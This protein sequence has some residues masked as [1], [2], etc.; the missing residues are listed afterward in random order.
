[1]QEVGNK[2]VAFCGNEGVFFFYGDNFA[3]FGP[4]LECIVLIGLYD[5]S[6]TV[7]IMV[8]AVTRDGATSNRVD[9]GIDFKG[10]QGEVSYQVVASRDSKAIVGLC[11]DSITVFR[12][13]HEF[14]SSGRCGRYGASLSIG[15]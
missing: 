15:I 12:P 5:Q 13:V 2:V 10:L 3:V 9:D 4:V 1:M 6:N 11:R 14:K 7:S 8:C